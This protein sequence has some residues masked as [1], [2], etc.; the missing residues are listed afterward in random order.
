MNK[1]G[2]DR[3][4]MLNPSKHALPSASSTGGAL[5]VIGRTILG[6][7]LGAGL[8]APLLG[9]EVTGYVKREIF[10]APGAGEPNGSPAT[11]ANPNYPD[12]P[13]AVTFLDSWV[14]P[15]TAN[16]NVEDFLTKLSGFIKPATTG[17][18]VFFYAGD[19]HGAFYLSTDD[20]PSN[21]KLVAQET[22]WSNPLQWQTSGGASSIADKNSSTFAGTKWPTGGTIRLEAGKKYYAVA[23]GKEGGGGD[24]TCVTMVKASDVVVPDFPAEGDASTLTGSLIS[25]EAPTALGFLKQPTSVTIEQGRPASFSVIAVTPPGNPVQDGTLVTP[26]VTYQWRK[27]GTDIPVA[28]VDADGVPD[29]GSSGTATYA[30]AS[31]VVADNGAK[32]TCKITTSGGQTVTSAEAI[33]TVTVDTT[34]P[35]IAN[36][37]SS[38]DGKHVT[39]TYSEAMDASV[40]TAGNYSIS[41]G[42]TV[43]AAA[44]IP[45]AIPSSPTIVQLTTSLQPADSAY[46]LTVNNVK[47]A[48]GNALTAKTAPFRSFVFKSGIVLY[49]RWDD[50]RNLQTFLDEGGLDTFPTVSSVLGDF[51]S[52]NGVADNYTAQMNGYFAP[53]TTGDYVFFCSSDDQ[54]F[55]FLSTDEIPSKK[56]KIATEPQWNN[57]RDWL[58]PDRRD[59]DNPEN[60]SDKWTSTEWPTANTITLQQGKKYYIEFVFHEGGGGDNGSAT[61]KLASAAD[62]ANGT[63]SALTGGVIGNY[64]DSTTLPPTAP[65]ITTRP[66]GRHFKKGDTLTFTAAATASDPVTYQWFRSKKPIA[67]ATGTT[68][69][70][71]NAGPEAVGDYM[72]V[73]TATNKN[74][75]VSTESY[76]D[77]DVRAIMDDAFV[78]ES[79]DFNHGGGKTVAAASTMPLAGNLYD[80]LDGLPGID[81]HLVGQSTGDGAA[82]GNAY[83]NGSTAVVDFPTSPEALGNVDITGDGG[84]SDR[85][86]YTFTT[87]YKIGWGDAGEWYQYTRDFPPGVYNAVLSAGL[88][89]RGTDNLGSTLQIVTGDPTKVGAATTTVGTLLSNGTGAWSSDDLI[90]YKNADG[91]MA[92]M[93]LGAKTTVR[94]VMS[95]GGY[96]FDYVLFYKIRD[97]GGS[98][99]TIAIG[100]DGKITYTGTLTGADNAAGPFTPV[101]GATSPFTPNTG[102]AAQKFYRSSN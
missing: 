12:S 17:D 95:V 65:V 33:L 71:A 83:R 28:D 63:A 92:E 4:H 88:D 26:D 102:A 40:G 77:D 93:T 22:V 16:P 18:Y 64:V 23:L 51:N 11:F 19:D 96:D 58:L 30:I 98:G 34:A 89:G 70:I 72:F 6:L 69:T 87:N 97:I 85:G 66:V 47:D 101:S 99:P 52:P 76:P 75:S 36:A 20:S 60:R 44:I 84:N 67:G 54:G 37:T 57:Q 13:D 68:L 74:G 100:A 48:A 42:V 2:D 86:S 1:S 53:A 59:A 79:E 73:V 21:L 50:T 24:S 94:T 91:T 56:V 43:S 45:P 25:T 32:F 62:P 10:R 15:Q 55:L 82:N 3:K 9:A 78:I 41:G 49:K 7:A 90:G 27:N 39:V 31:G 46:T 38:V 14:S 29:V 5:R 80:G 8:C 81:F 61:F 35:T